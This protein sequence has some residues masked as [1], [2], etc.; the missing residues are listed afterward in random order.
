MFDSIYHMTIRLLCNLI[1]LG[2]NMLNCVIMYAMLLWTSLQ[3]A[4]KYA[5]KRFIV[6]NTYTFFL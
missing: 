6:F 2:T 4:T 3:N 1:I 5:N